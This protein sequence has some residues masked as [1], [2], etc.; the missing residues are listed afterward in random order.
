MAQDITKRYSNG[1]VTVIW[2]PA[3]CQHSGI[4][5]RGL[6]AVFNPSRRPWI[7]L[8]HSDTATITA[9]VERCPSGAL[10]WEKTTAD[11]SN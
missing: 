5:A 2:K 9:Q 7:Q 6:P 11:N 1:A 4:C 10:S 8:E 3:L